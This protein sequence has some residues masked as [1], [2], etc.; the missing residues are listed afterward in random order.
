M[1]PREASGQRKR[2]TLYEKSKSDGWTCHS[3]TAPVPIGRRVAV[4]G[5]KEGGAR[6]G[7]GGIMAWALHT[8]AMPG[9]TCDPVTLAAMRRREALGVVA[10]ITPWNYPL[11]MATV[12]WGVGE[13]RLDGCRCWV[14]A[15][16]PRRSHAPRLFMATVGWVEGDGSKE[17]GNMGRD[18][19]RKRR[20][21]QGEHVAGTTQRKLTPAPTAPNAMTPRP[22]S[23]SF[24]VLL[25]S[26]CPFPA[27]PALFPHRYPRSAAAAATPSEPHPALPPRS[28]TLCVRPSIPHAPPQTCQPNFSPHAGTS[29]SVLS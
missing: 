13:S 5:Q 19:G 4:S 28:S 12:S 24:V 8:V 2:W 22:S 25:S 14:R 9:V 20:R 1:K 11:L 27:C 15:R 3:P 17:E 23:A 29:V 7:F 16:D 18:G 6:V 10:L 26:T 21:A